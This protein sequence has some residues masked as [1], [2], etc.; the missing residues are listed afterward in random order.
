[1]K[2]FIRKQGRIS[3]PGIFHMLVYFYLSKKYVNRL[4]VSRCIQGFLQGV[5]LELQLHFLSTNSMGVFPLH[6]YI[7]FKS[8]EHQ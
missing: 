3:L 2:L 5:L 4:K 1:L 8:Y 6:R 7:I